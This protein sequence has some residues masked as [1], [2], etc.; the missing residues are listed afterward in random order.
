M[1]K[2]YSVK[3]FKKMI[4]ENS[5]E[6]KAKIGDN[7]E[8]ENKKNNNK[9]YQDAKTRSGAKDEKTTHDSPKKVDGNKGVTDY[10]FDGEVSDNFKKKVHAQAQGYTSVAEKDNG[11]EKAADF[12][13]DFYKQAKEAG[14]E[15]DKNKKT[16]NKTGLRSRELPDNWFEKE[17]MYESKSIKTVRFKNTEFLTE[18]HMISKIPDE[19][20]SYGNIFK[21][22]DKNNNTYIVEWKNNDDDK[23]KIIEHSNPKAVNES[24]E[25]MKKLYNYRSSQHYAT[26]TGNE[27][28]NESNNGFTTTLKNI[29]KINS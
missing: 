29:R 9:S 19:M 4:N 11:I 22:C 8:K 5:D 26:T 7:V 10:R 23:T 16:F 17:N 24:L 15:M 28:L 13:D 1:E 25:K 27:R 20:K 18:E 6:F 3:N 14:E 21:M 12:N 2:T